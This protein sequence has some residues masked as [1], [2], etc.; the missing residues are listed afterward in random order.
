MTMNLTA[1]MTQEVTRPTHTPAPVIPDENPE[2]RQLKERIF[3]N[4]GARYPEVYSPRNLINPTLLTDGIRAA[5]RIAHAINTGQTIVLVADFDCDGA[6]S[7]AILKRALDS[8]TKILWQTGHPKPSRKAVVHHVIPDRFLYG[9]GLKP[10]LAEKVIRPLNPDL[11]IT[12]DNGI[13]SHDAVDRIKTWTGVSTFCPSGAPDVIVTDHHAQGDTLPDAYAVVNPN[14]K[15]CQ[16][17]SKALAGCGVAFYMVILIRQALMTL[18]KRQGNM[19]ALRAVSKFQVNHFADLVAIGTIGD[20]VPMDANNRLLVKVGLDRINKGLQMP[21]RKAHQEGYLSFGVRALLEVANVQ[22]PVKTSDIAF[23]VAPRIN[24]VGRIEKPLAGIECLLSETQMIANIEAKKCHQLNE[25]RKAIQKEMQAEAD[26][27]MAELALDTDALLA[28]LPDNRSSNEDTPDS[29]DTP[30]PL[31]AVILHDDN[32]HPGIVGLIASRIKDRTKGAVIC[33]SPE[34]DPRAEPGSPEAEGDPDWLKG[35]GR[36]DNVH[37]RDAV[38][39]VVARAP[40]MLIQFGGHARAMGLSLH[41]TELNRFTRL[42]KEAVAHGL[43]TAPLHNPDYQDGA[44][45]AHLRTHSLIKWIERQPWGQG[46]P[47][48]TFTQIFKVIRV[49]PVGTEHQR[50]LLMDADEQP[51]SQ[52]NLPGEVTEPVYAT[53]SNRESVNMIWFFSRNQGDRL[54]VHSNPELQLPDGTVQPGTAVK[55]TYNLAINRFRG[56][57]KVQGVIRSLEVVGLAQ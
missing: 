20:L 38:A 19:N 3:E 55:V 16:F 46:F 30:N 5:S 34:V 47:E 6:T 29:E 40:N 12:L 43:A 27:K 9:Y 42:F 56:S 50:V 21:A 17:P 51:L 28:G 24:A 11:I 26:A 14:R 18:F 41:R 35:S 48:P 33:F 15:D 39:Y 32:W 49:Q 37:I 45:P 36:S 13:S 8:L 31:A 23:Q 54:A 52:H 1:K 57:S 25:E 7:A 2:V 22:Y 44:L 53:A 4:R 10:M